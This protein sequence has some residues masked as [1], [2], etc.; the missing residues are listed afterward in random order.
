MLHAQKTIS[1]ETNLDAVQF[2]SK[3]SQA[4]TYGN[5]QQ[6]KKNMCRPFHPSC[7]PGRRELTSCPTAG[8]HSREDGKENVNSTPFEG[9]CF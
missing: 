5:E 1:R 7:L 8:S 6:Q 3:K 2:I 4:N 9:S